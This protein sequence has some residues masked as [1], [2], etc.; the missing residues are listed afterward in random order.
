MQYNMKACFWITASYMQYNI[1][2]DLNKYKIEDPD[3]HDILSK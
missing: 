3:L 2:F 1:K